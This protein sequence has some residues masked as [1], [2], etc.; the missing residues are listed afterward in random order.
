M[1]ALE[2][3]LHEERPDLPLLVKAGLSHVQFETIHPFLDGNGRL[4]RL[5]ITFLL[6]ADGALREPLLYLSLYLKQHR[7]TYYDLLMRVRTHGEWE[8]WLEFFLKGIRATADQ[9]V[10]SARR[11]LDLLNEDRRKVDALGR[12]AGSVLRVF[13]LAQDTLVLS[14]PHAA[15]KLGISFPTASAAFRRCPLLSDRCAGDLPRARIERGS[16]IGRW[17]GP[18][19]RL[20]SRMWSLL[21][22]S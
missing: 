13:Q 11:I 19:S 6:C 14:V 22:R 3:F 17:P 8:E 15:Q 21:P 20:R 2:L 18:E 16:R 10:A 12:A 5:L 1:G 4:G 9:A 7:Q